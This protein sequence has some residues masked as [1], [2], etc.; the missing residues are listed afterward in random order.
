MPEKKCQN[1]GHALS[2]SAK[3][4]PEC[5][6]SVSGYNKS[7][8]A[9]PRKNH[10][11]IISFLVVATIFYFVFSLV[12][13]KGKTVEEDKPHGTVRTPSTTEMA[14]YR[15]NLPD[16]FAPL[17]QMGNSLMDQG[18]FQLAIECYSKALQFDSTDPNVRVDLGTCQFN[19]GDSPSAI[20]NFKKALEFTPSHQTA[21]F[22][23]GI[24]YF[25]M[26]DT[27]SAIE[28]WSK[29]LEENPAPDLRS[30]TEDLMMQI[31]GE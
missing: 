6:A 7:K 2:Q 19:F 31:M 22:N 8:K 23:L 20:A 10:I 18:Q 24:V 12:G 1:C 15:E 29:L 9:S 5:G 13:D 25:S 28:W 21:K 3:F 14:A 17:V 11:I 26:A 27:T 30:R 16:S 4:C